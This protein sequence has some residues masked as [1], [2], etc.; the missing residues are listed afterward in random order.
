MQLTDAISYT[1][2]VH[3][4]KSFAPVTRWTTVNSV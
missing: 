3:F 1:H 4:G 2:E